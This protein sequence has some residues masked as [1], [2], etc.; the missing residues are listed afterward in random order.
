MTALW[1]RDPM[2][3]ELSS[4]D[5][6]AAGLGDVSGQFN[7]TR[8]IIENLVLD[9]VI[10]TRT[11]HIAFGSI[12]LALAILV[13]FRIWYDSW[14]ASKLQVK[15]RPRFVIFSEKWKCSMLILIG[16]GRSYTIY[17]QQ[18]AFRSFWDSSLSFNRYHLLPFRRL[19]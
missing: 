3:P 18:R 7:K 15:L 8:D 12:S 10:Q 16:N 13:I 1:A 9:K 5:R 17:I 2:K 19:L 4:L 14:R 11:M 6:G